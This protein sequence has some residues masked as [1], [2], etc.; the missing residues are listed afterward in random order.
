MRAILRSISHVLQAEDDGRIF[1][2]RK[3]TSTPP[4]SNRIIRRLP[5]HGRLTEKGEGMRRGP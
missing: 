2:G 4:M 3:S 1:T 5:M